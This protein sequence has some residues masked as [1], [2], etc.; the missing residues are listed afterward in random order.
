MHIQWLRACAQHNVLLC[1]SLS[2]VIQEAN[3][4]EIE[5]PENQKFESQGMDVEMSDIKEIIWLPKVTN[6]LEHEMN[7]K[8]LQQI[9]NSYHIESQKLDKEK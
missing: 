5:I 4:S 9:V 7:I 6:I 1:H 8:T 3:R 2:V